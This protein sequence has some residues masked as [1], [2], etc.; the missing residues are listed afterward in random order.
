MKQYEHLNLPEY[1]HIFKRQKTK[2]FSRFE[3][4]EG[5]IKSNFAKKQEKKT[6]IKQLTTLIELK[7]ITSYPQ[8]KEVIQNFTF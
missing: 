1:Q 2:G 3:L 8:L 4:P 5:R 7:M 6:M